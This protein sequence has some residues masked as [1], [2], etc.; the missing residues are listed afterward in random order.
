LVVGHIGREAKARLPLLAESDR[1]LNQKFVDE[2]AR[3]ACPHYR[4]AKPL[5][6]NGVRSTAEMFQLMDSIR[7]TSGGSRTLWTSVMDLNA[8]TMEVRYLKE[9]DRKYDFRF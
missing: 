4:K 6:E 9:F 7:E 3:S 1:P 8:R 5:L 2:K